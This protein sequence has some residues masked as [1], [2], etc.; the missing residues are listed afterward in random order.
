MKFIN[1]DFQKLADDFKRIANAFKII[2]DYPNKEDA[3]FKL[4]M[5]LLSNE[6]DRLFLD[7]TQIH[8]NSGSEK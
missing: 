2:Q 7:L 5:E 3:I 8:E 4:A 6:L 1:G